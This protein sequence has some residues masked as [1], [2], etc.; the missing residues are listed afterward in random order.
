MM[1]MKGVSWA[2]LVNGECMGV[3]R[4]RGKKRQDVYSYSQFLLKRKT[5]D[6]TMETKFS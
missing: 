5:G 4:E 3:W 1:T 2:G 6:S